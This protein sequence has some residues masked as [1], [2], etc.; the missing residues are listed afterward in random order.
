MGFIRPDIIRPPSEARSYYLPLTSGCSNNSCIY[1]NYYGCKLQIRDPEEVK[2]EVDIIDSFLKYGYRIPELP[3]IAYAIADEWDCKRIFL[4]DGD[5]LVYPFPQ[6]KEIFEYINLKFPQLERIGSY[7]T[8]QDILHLTTDQLKVLNQSK[9]G[10]IYL[11]VESGDDEVL[12]FI[13]KGVNAAEIIEAG[14]KIKDAGILLS[15]SVL[16]G[17]GGVEKSRQHALK[18]SEILSRLDSDYAGALTVTLI[19]GTPLHGMCA[20]GKFSLITPFQSLEE[21]RIII[22][23]AKFTHCFFSSMHASNYLSVRGV[24]PQ[25][26]S[27]MLAKIDYVLSRKDPALLRPEFMRGL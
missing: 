1:C 14:E 21:L 11:G 8:P 16:L 3:Y 18:T 15:V 26:K 4:Q 2:K 13:G 19:P 5:A 6:L 27:E 23:N 12:K 22:T 9:L 10:I 24:L 7:A 20:K 25:D 17:L